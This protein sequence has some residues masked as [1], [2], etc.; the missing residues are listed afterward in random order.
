MHLALT[1][2][3][4]LLSIPAMTASSASSQCANWSRGFEIPGVSGSVHAT[5]LFDDGGGTALFVGGAFSSVGATP[6]SNI[7]RWDG[8]TWSALS[9]EFDSTI[10]AL[11]VYDD[12][13][14]PALYAGG[15]FTQIGTTTGFNGIAKWNGSTWSPL[16]MGKNGLVSALQV[17]DAGSGPALYVGG[18]FFEAGPLTVHNVAR[19]DG[20]AWSALGN[21]LTGNSS[22]TV[23]TFAV[24]DSGSSPSLYAG[25]DFDSSST[26]AV[27]GIAR[28]TGT[29]WVGV[30]GGV[31]PFGSVH[32]LSVSTMVRVRGC[33][34][35]AISRPPAGSRR[36][37]SH[38]GTAR[39]GRRS[40][41]AYSAAFLQM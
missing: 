29:Q 32:A 37:T 8:T 33:T 2:R 28:W 18:S 5:C 26:T 9:D 17:F 39:I 30:G 1:L 23:E 40:A 31:G 16:G 35:A 25:G 38:V 3:L 13:T 19:W 4:L 27:T 11:A 41:T 6:A 12:G 15:A 24:Y 10:L 21:G 34:R 36:S 20:T 22:S 7:A 14:G